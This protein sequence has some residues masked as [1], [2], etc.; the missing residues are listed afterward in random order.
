MNEHSLYL[1]LCMNSVFV[2]VC[3][4][5]SVCACFLVVICKD[6]ICVCVCV[7]MMGERGVGIH[8]SC[9]RLYLSLKA[10]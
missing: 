8:K 9:L 7:C 1:I 4:C 2:C 6:V 10:E 5:V 3:L